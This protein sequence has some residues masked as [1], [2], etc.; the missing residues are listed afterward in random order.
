MILHKLC[1]LIVWEGYYWGFF[2]KDLI[3]Q[4][5]IPVGCL[6]PACQPYMRRWSPDV[7]TRGSR[8]VNKF[9]Q[10]SID[11][12]Q[13]SLAGVG[14][15]HVPMALYS[16]VQCITGN[17]DMGPSFPPTEWQTD[18]CEI[19][20]FPQFRWLAVTMCQWHIQLYQP[21]R[22]CRQPIILTTFWPKNACKWKKWDRQRGAR[23]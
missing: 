9:E 11:G 6:S 1:S 17:G 20:T 23:P 8:Q 12:H 15:P 18:I 10:V 2:F 19:I 21:Q 7:S 14:G 22:G 3:S 13:M 16:V 5:S 4:E